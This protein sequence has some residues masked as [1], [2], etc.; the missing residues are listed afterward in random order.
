MASDRHVPLD[1]ESNFR[2]LGGYDTVDGRTV[3]SGQVYRSGRLVELTDPDV[4]RLGELGV[5]TVVNFVTDDDREAYGEDRVPEGVDSVPLPIDS[6]TATR[7]THEA[8]TALHSGNFAALPPQLNPEIHRLLV[9]D[10]AASY[11]RLI[12][13]AAD[14]HRRPLVFHCSHGVHRT[15]TGAAILLTLLGVPWETVR[16]DYLLSNTYREAEVRH[17]LEQL[18]T[19]AA[20][21]QGIPP[22][23]V[24][25]TN[26]DAFMIQDGTYIDA[27]RDEVIA[28]FGSFDR[29]A[30]EALALDPAVINQLRAT[31]LD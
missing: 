10:G 16:T 22:D 12:E 3:R 26:V 8:I 20:Q 4:L 31:L 6:D 7:L 14:P 17:R 15:G 18:R 30:N 9:H 2:D 25:M 23:D 24:D 11:R 19:L 29:Y 5:R 21:S 27:T 13:L 1:G 28:K